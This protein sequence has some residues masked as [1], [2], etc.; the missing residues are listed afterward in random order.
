MVPEMFVRWSTHR[1]TRSATS[2]LSKKRRIHYFVMSLPHSDGIFII[3][4]GDHGTVT[5]PFAFLGGVPQ[6]ILYDP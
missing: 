3:S 2:G 4:W 1:G 6:S 5:C